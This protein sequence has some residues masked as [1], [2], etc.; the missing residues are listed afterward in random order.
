[1]KAGTTLLLLATLLGGAHAS[2]APVTL[3]NGGMQDGLAERAVTITVNVPAGTIVGTQELW[4]ENF[5]GI[6]YAEPA[7][8]L[9]PPVRRQGRLNNF[10]ATTAAPACPQQIAD[11]DS[12]DFLAKVISTVANTQLFKQA[13]KISED[14]LNIN[15]IRPKG[16]KAGDKLPVL[17]WIYGGGFELGWNSMYDGS[18]LVKSGLDVG[19]PFVFVAGELSLWRPRSLARA[20]AS[21]GLG[22]GVAVCVRAVPGLPSCRPAVCAAAAARM[23]HRHGAAEGCSCKASQRIGAVPGETADPL[24][25]PVVVIQ[26]QLYPR[27]GRSR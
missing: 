20:L 21:G 12:N 1:M 9:R 7:Q 4:T 6:P 18:L 24:R 13:L 5:N 10:D 23:G 3:S 8:R 27:R 11:S 25:P 22:S 14:C 19:K 17:F 2:P 16:T 26:T 15:V